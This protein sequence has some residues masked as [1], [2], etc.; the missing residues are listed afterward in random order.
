MHKNN[1]KQNTNKTYES[2]KSSFFKN[3]TD[4]LAIIGVNLAIAAILT[5]MWI[6]NSH[7]VDAANARSDALYVMFYDLLKEG[8]K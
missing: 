4:T 2:R 1:F 3:H 5:T 6:S 8:K 7:R